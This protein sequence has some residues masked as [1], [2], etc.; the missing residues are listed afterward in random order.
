MEEDM[1]L[2]RSVFVLALAALTAPL[3]FGEGRTTE[4]PDATPHDLKTVYL[5]CDRASMDRRLSQA[6]MMHCSMVYEELKWRVFDGDFEK[7]FAWSRSSAALQSTGDGV[8]DGT[9]TAR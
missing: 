1:S 5:A 6:E 9:L 3:A 4:M 2:A 7:L 8:A